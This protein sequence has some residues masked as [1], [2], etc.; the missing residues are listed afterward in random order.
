MAEPAARTGHASQ[1][2]KP[3]PA[4]CGRT[5]APRV[6]MRLSFSPP[7][8]RRGPV[9][10][11]TTPRLWT[12]AGHR[13]RCGRSA[14]KWTSFQRGLQRGGKGAGRAGARSGARA[15]CVAEDEQRENADAG[16]P[17]GAPRTLVHH[18]GRTHPRPG[19][20]SCTGGCS[21]PRVL[22][23]PSWGVGWEKASTRGN[24][25]AR[26]EK[27]WTLTSFLPRSPPR[28][29]AARSTRTASHSLSTAR[30]IQF[31]CTRGS[32][33][34]RQIPPQHTLGGAS[35]LALLPRARPVP[36]PHKPAP[37]PAPWRDRA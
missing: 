32:P 18:A 37:W 1:R 30:P 24:V 12:F 17:E 21:W 29:R 31:S 10:Q 4:R 8:P 6:V 33:A 35:R 22:V 19:G 28:A 15:V 5:Q 25:R 20:R 36:R 27:T 2:R 7:L 11:S 3:G 26:C 14:A 16:T 34:G 23:E 13:R 9:C